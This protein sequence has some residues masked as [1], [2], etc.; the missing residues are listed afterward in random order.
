MRAVL[1]HPGANA[2]AVPRRCCASRSQPPASPRGARWGQRRARRTCAAA[3]SEEPEVAVFRFTL[4]RDQRCC[5]ALAG[6]Q[7]ATQTE[8][9]ARFG[10]RQGIPGFDDA[11]LPRVRCAAARAKLATKLN[12]YSLRGAGHRR[13]RRPA[14]S[15]EPR[16]WRSRGLRPPACSRTRPSWERAR[17]GGRARTAPGDTRR[18]RVDGS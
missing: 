7:G 16:A 9:D 17:R 6:Q 2:L 12:A 4:A 14:A 3:A 13:S 8:A 15:R 11:Q 18:A 5:A 1:S 10:L